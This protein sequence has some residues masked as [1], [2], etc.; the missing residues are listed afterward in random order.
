M[1]KYSHLHYLLGYDL[2]T[3]GNNTRDAMSFCWR[4]SLDMNWIEL[5]IQN[6]LYKLL[7]M[8]N[9]TIPIIYNYCL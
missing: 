7:Y 6:L 8:V 4:E 5:N 9:F 3:I 1:K 2:W